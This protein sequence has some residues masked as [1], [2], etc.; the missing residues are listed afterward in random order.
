MRFFELATLVFENLGRRIGR[1]AL[2]AI[3]VVIGTAAIVVLV[4]LAIGMQ[5]SA[6]SQLLGIGDLKQIQ[7]SPGW[8][9]TF[10]PQGPTVLAPITDQTLLDFTALPGVVSVVPR[11]FLQGGAM[12]K[13][14]RL[15]TYGNFYGV[16]TDDLSN[17]GLSAEQGNLRLERGTVVIGKMVPSNF[18]DPN[19]RPGQEPPQPPDLMDKNLKITLIK[20]DQEGQEIRKTVQLRVSGIIVETRG[21]S[22]WSMYIPIEELNIWN[23]WFMGKR[24]NRDRDGYNSAVVQVESPSQTIEVTDQIIAMGYQAY[25]PQSF[26]EG[27]NSFYIVLQVMFGG[28][29]AIALLVAAIGIANTM[30]MAILERTRE[31][32][33]MKAVGATNRQVLG[34]F[35]GEAAGI[36]FIGGLGGIL[37]GWVVGQIVNVLSLVYMAG[38]ASQPMSPG[39]QMPLLAV[40]TPPWLLGFALLFAVMIGLLSGIYPALRAAT[41]IPVQALKYE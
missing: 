7:V 15:E 41:L 14:G 40:Y 22:D 29:G 28:V 8:S 27:I 25:T 4:S 36:G 39:G 34:I 24:V 23:Q 3:G 17:L 19:F 26:V 9:E 30:T 12:I 11:D 2:T 10:G 5:R 1:V 33:L 21:E 16:G 18:Y 32:G 38:Q 37:V 31:I 35:L 20:Y 13:M 6:N